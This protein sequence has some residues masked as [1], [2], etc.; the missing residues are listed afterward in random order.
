V[1]DPERLAA[2]RFVCARDQLA[3]G[4][5]A[6]TFAVVRAGR[7]LPAIAYAFDGEVQA[8]IN[9]CPH[10]GTTLDWQPGEVFD[11]SG[12]YLIC[13]THGAMFDPVSGSCIA[14]PCV[15][16]Q[17]QK[18]PVQVVDGRVEL[19]FDCRATPSESGLP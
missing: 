11:E 9:V 7:T 19:V 3:D 2:L 5:R 14:G 12:L 18:L 6:L 13:A 17:L 16:A 4:G 15:G 8:A 1:A 10:R